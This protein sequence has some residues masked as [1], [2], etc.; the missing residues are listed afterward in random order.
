MASYPRVYLLLLLAVSV[1][2]QNNTSEPDTEMVGWVS[3]E[4]K[5]STAE[6]L[7]GCFSVFLVCSWNCV[8]LNL[9]SVNESEAGW[10]KTLGGK[11]PYW[12]TFRYR[13]LF[14]RRLGWMISIFVAPEFGVAM[15]VQDF[16]AARHLEKRLRSPVFTMS[17]AFYACM[18]GFDIEIWTTDSTD[19]A[20]PGAQQQY[21]PVLAE[22]D[23]QTQS[24]S[25]HFTKAFALL[26][27]TW[28]VAQS[29]SRVAHGLPLTHLELSTLA[30]IPCALAMH[31]F[32]W[33]KPFDAQ[34]AI[35]L[36]CLDQSKAAIIRTSLPVRRPNTRV[37]ELRNDA[38]DFFDPLEFKQ[39]SSPSVLL[40]LAFYVTAIAFSSVHMLAWNWESPLSLVWKVLSI[41]AI[42]T[43]V[44]VFICV[45]IARPLLSDRSFAKIHYNHVQNG[46]G[47]C[48]LPL[49]FAY[50]L[51]RFGMFSIM[52]IDLQFLP[53]AVYRTVPW[54][55]VFP[56]FS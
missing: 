4:P 39:L 24:R 22:A 49:Y 50:V 47:V 16:L 44:A 25:D 45:L 7:W 41:I 43:P 14:R 5:R 13:R 20:A 56:H 10:K 54:S 2:A 17:H 15:A 38:S 52:I 42:A 26:Q 29:L 18:G 48:V 33:N 8:H 1:L 36:L 3:R 21:F 30:F 9:P 53:A 32:W 35:P 23:I 12:P 40:S 55:D 46:L 6:I 28:L 31:A 27:C 11:L 37:P 34:H 19:S 51:S